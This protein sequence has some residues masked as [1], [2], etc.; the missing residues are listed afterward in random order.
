MK[1][2][3]LSFSAIM[4]ALATVLM[5]VGYFPYLTYA[6]PCVASLAIMAVVIELGARSAFLTYLASLLPVFLFCETETKLLYICFMGF[7]PALKAI[8]ERLHSRV[9]EYLLKL[10]C[11]NAAVGVIYL[12][13]SFVFGVSF[14]D[15]GELGKYGAV[16]F[17]G[18]ANFAFI[19]YD[20]CIS[21]MSQFYMF[22]LHN[23]VK[24]MLK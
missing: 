8:L 11:F 17:L 10:V 21:K 20:Y 4:A 2:K 23:T 6:V 24:K 13:S 5:L 9:L 15:L 3:H 12:L 1:T 19:A 16:I 14:D 22:K 7:Y 18:M